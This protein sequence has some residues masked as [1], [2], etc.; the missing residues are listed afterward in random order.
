MLN[1]ADTLTAARFALAEGRRADLATLR[2]MLARDA[3]HAPEGQAAE[4]VALVILLD[5]AIRGGGAPA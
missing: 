1:I 3:A 2:A 5:A 4:A